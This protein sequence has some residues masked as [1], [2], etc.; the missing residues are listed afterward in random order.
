MSSNLDKYRIEVDL[1][2][3]TEWESL[4]PDFEDATIHQSWSMGAQSFGEQNL[5]RLVLR[6]DGAVIGMAQTSI[7]RIPVLGAG[8]AR[9]FWGPLWRRKGRQP[10]YAILDAIVEALKNEYVNRRG[11][12]LRLWP[13][14]F[15]DLENGTVN[16][17]KKHGFIRKAGDRPY[18]TLLLDLSSSIEDLRKNLAQKW[19]NQLN[20]AEKSNLLIRK[21]NSSELYAIFLQMLRETVSRKKFESGVDYDRYGKIQADLPEHLKMKIYVCS[22]DTIP[23]AAGVFSL[24]GKTAEYL[25]GATANSGLRANG[26]NLIHWHV[27]EWLKEEGAQY[28]DLGGIDPPGNPGVY[29]FKRG[30]A[31]KSGIEVTHLGQFVLV[32]NRLSHLLGLCLD[33]TNCVRNRLRSQLRSSNERE[34]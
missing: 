4:L 13:V 33:R 1:T 16:V 17:L 25:L 19:R 27:I 8:I 14:G 7:R 26:S 18:R 15:Q 6:R 28:Y 34:S 2:E 24:I 20:G 5:S 32:N 29:R 22:R 11:L 21:G 12:L 3:K 31:G 23:V 30:L 9:L 10:D